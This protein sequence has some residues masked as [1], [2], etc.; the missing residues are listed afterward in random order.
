MRKCGQRG[1]LT[2][3]LE[4]FLRHPP[5]SSRGGPLFRHLTDRG[6]ANNQ[7]FPWCLCGLIPV[8]E[9]QPAGSGGYKA[10]VRS[11]PPGHCHLRARWRPLGSYGTDAG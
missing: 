2:I 3:R 6:G 10:A 11:R 7:S 1:G 8:P 4:G 5:P 9:Y